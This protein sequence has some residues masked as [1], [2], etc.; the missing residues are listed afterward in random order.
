MEARSCVNA[1]PRESWLRSAVEKGAMQQGNALP[2]ALMYMRVQGRMQADHGCSCASAK[3]LAEGVVAPEASKEIPSERARHSA[4]LIS[5]PSTRSNLSTH[6]ATPRSCQ[7]GSRARQKPRPPANPG[8]RRQTAQLR[9]PPRV[10]T[11]THASCAD[12]RRDGRHP[13]ADSMRR[14]CSTRRCTIPGGP[15]PY[16]RIACAAPFRSGPLNQRTGVAGSTRRLA[17][18]ADSVEEDKRCDPAK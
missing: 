12:C 15:F 14:H 18:K 8:W 17:R 7:V 10:N 4:D 3:R 5:L 9:K 13:S 2:R 16:A 6:P 1:F 11:P